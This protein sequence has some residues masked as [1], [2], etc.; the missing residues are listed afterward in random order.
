MEF[1]RS[2]S[3]DW[4]G[5]K[6]YFL[7]F[8][9]IFSIAGIVSMGMH[10]H[11]IGSPVPLGVDFRGGTEVQVQ[12]QNAPD[13]NAIREAMSASGIKD[14]RIQAYNAEAGSN[15]VLITSSVLFTLFS[16]P[17]ATSQSGGTLIAGPGATL[18]GTVVSN[19]NPTPAISNGNTTL[20]SGSAYDTVIF[21]G[22]K[23]DV[24]SGIGAL[25]AHAICGS[26]PRGPGTR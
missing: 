14:A 17:G 4:L 16:A 19:A 1:F 5:K 9:M 11:S 2:V 22:G 12:F 7:G 8:S 6:W 10:W 15:Q 25:A 21:G 13:I 26:S 20:K 23:Q 18:Y 24:D 3:I